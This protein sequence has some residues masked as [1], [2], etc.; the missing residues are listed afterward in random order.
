MPQRRKYT[1]SSPQSKAKVHIS[2][3]S[4]TRLT[5]KKYLSA[6]KAFYEWQRA[7]G[8][9]AHPNLPEF[10]LQLGEYLNY[11]YQGGMPLYLGTNCIAGFKK[12][13]PRCRRH[14]ETAVCWLNNWSRVTLK[15]QAM[16]MHA[17]LCKA[18]VAYGLLRKELDFAISIYVGFLALLRGCEI[19]HLLLAD[20]QPRGPDQMC[21]ILRD[22]KGAKLKNLPFE[23]VTIRDPLAIKILLRRKALN[24]RCL[25]NG[26]PADFYRLYKEAVAFYHV[27]H[28]K[29]TPHGIRRGGAS[30]HFQLHG[31]FDRTVEHGRWGSVASARTYINEAA[32]E[33]AASSSNLLGKRRLKDAVESCSSLLSSAFSV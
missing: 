3:A 21:L 23:T 13:H 31:S 24:H 29:P 8:L 2:Q 30:W 6:M 14:I 19:F 15:V 4:I 7:E 1:R 16:P 25:F 27:A 33:E 22:T 5:V 26:K 10:D 9:S 20:C 18:F 12:F 28:P 17:D 11:L 32:A